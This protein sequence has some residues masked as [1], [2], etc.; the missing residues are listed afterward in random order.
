[1]KKVKEKEKLLLHHRIY[2]AS[3]HHQ[4]SIF[5]CPNL[6]L[7]NDKSKTQ[8]KDSVMEATAGIARVEDKANHAPTK[9]GVTYSL[10]KPHALATSRGSR[11][12]TQ[13]KIEKW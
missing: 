13:K 7:D 8:D 10:A 5:L 9:S 3:T 11:G 2:R 6:Y 12:K 4:P 1:L